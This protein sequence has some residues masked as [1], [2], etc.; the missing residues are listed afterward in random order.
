VYSD[1]FFI[2]YNDKSVTTLLCTTR[3]CASVKANSNQ[4]AILGIP[5]SSDN[6]MHRT[7]KK[8]VAHSLVTYNYIISDI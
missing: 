4:N 8:N 3:K 2:V 5:S 6:T 1:K 7:I